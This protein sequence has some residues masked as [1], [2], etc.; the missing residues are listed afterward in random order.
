VSND[1]QGFLTARQ[2][3]LDQLERAFMLAH[4]VTEPKQGAQPEPSPIDTE[5]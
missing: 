2:Q 5:D 1:P 4:G 3:Y